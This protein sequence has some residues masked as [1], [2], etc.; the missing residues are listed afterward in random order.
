MSDNS[1]NSTALAVEMI[2]QEFGIFIFI[3]SALD[4]DRIRAAGHE[5]AFLKIKKKIK[6]FGHYMIGVLISAS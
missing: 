6:N 3:E 1:G 2:D 4:R 5:K